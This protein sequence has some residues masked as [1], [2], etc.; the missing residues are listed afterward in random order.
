MPEFGQENALVARRQ[1]AMRRPPRAPPEGAALRVGGA[2]VL[3]GPRILD[4]HQQ[5]P[6]MPKV[7]RRVTFTVYSVIVPSM[8]AFPR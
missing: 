8:L 1:S 5:V 6:G 2:A 7:L 4:R 3:G